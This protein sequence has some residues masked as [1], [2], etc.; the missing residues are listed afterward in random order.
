MSA[1]VPQQTE[2]SS[3]ASSASR[4]TGPQDM[5]DV[6]LEQGRVVFLYKS[7][8]PQDEAFLRRELV[9]LEFEEARATMEEREARIG[10]MALRKAEEELDRMFQKLQK[11]RRA[12]L[13]SQEEVWFACAE[14]S[15]TF[16]RELSEVKKA[17]ADL[18]NAS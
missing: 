11:E 6:V 18:P 15:Q 5:A 7:R 9:R 14:K 1:S 12:Y 8:L 4:S 16:A 2:Q 13:N 10:V 17:L 3:Q